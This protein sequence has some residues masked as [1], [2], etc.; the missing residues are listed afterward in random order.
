[1]PYDRNGNYGTSF[2]P[3]KISP[4]PDG[5]VFAVNQNSSPN[6]V[7]LFKVDFTGNPVWGYEYYGL[8]S[9]N[10][11]DIISNGSGGFLV[12]GSTAD[13]TGLNYTWLLNADANGKKITENTIPIQGNTGWISGTIPQANGYVLG[14]SM[15]P[16]NTAY[17]D[18][19]GLLFTDQNGKIIDNGK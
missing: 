9:S 2:Y 1:M 8:A 14:V 13:P 15:I 5:Y 11:N 17:Q 3:E 18:R 6:S 12:S 19:F 10:C 7:F 4:A 16:S